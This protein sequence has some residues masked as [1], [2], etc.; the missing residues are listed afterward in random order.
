M[1]LSLNQNENFSNQRIENVAFTWLETP[2]KK[3]GRLKNVGVDCVG[4]VLGVLQEIEHPAG[5]RIQ[6][7]PNYNFNA[8]DPHLFDS[9]QMNF[10]QVNEL[11]APSIVLLNYYGEHQHI[12]M[13]LGDET[14]DLKLIH[15]DISARK[16]VVHR[17]DSVIKKRIQSIFK[18]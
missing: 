1:N 13:A 6:D 3:Y 8:K 15:A 14:T 16:V 12:G 7:K 11:K 5:S 17:I 18:I 9:L 10:E 4:L 2:F